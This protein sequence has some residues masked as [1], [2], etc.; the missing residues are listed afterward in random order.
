VCLLHPPQA[1]C[2][3]Q[4]HVCSTK[5]PPLNQK[6]HWSRF[7]TPFFPVAPVQCREKTL[8]KRGEK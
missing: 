8:N 1:Q 5:T 6:T 7:P 4:L 2:G 3:R